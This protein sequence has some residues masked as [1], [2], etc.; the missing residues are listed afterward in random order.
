MFVEGSETR[1]M[2]FLVVGLVFWLVAALDRLGHVA[3]ST[4]SVPVLMLIGAACLFVAASRGIR[5][6][7]A[8]LCARL[9]L[10]TVAVWALVA[11]DLTLTR[12]G[13]AHFV[14]GD[15]L[16][17][18]LVLLGQLLRIGLG[19]LGLGLLIATVVVALGGIITAL[20]HPRTGTA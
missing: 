7:Q 14:Y 4:F 13:Q 17:Y 1:A 2:P 19:L 5:H 10:A 16:L 18:F 11:L 3:F 12:I 6:E 9:G 15:L 8:R 20:R